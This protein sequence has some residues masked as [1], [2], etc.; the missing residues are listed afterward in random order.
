VAF[1]KENINNGTWKALGRPSWDQ[2]VC[3]QKKT[4]TCFLSIGRENQPVPE[5]LQIWCHTA[6][7]FHTGWPRAA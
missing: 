5:L 2:K 1:L 4:R 3:S 6:S 7:S